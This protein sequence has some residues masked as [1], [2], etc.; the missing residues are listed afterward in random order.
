MIGGRGGKSGGAFD[1][2]QR[3]R[4]GHLVRG[5]SLRVALFLLALFLLF[6][7]WLVLLRIKRRRL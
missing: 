4:G 3:G 5:G 7:R 2:G 6:G 1:G